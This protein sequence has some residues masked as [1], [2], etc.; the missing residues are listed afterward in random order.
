MDRPAPPA[1]SPVMARATSAKPS[2]STLPVELLDGI[3]QLVDNSDLIKLR[4]VSKTICAI[5]SR[6]FAARNFT[7]CYHVMSK[8]S[9]ETLLAISAHSI[10]G[11]CIK[12]IMVNSTRAILGY[13]NRFVEDDW[14]VES[15]EFS[16][17][18]PQILANIRRHTGSIT[19]GILEFYGGYKSTNRQRFHGENLFLAAG[20]EI[21]SRPS[22]TL[23]L[24][25][26]QMNAA[27]VD[28]NGLHFTV[29]LSQNA[30]NLANLKMY[31]MVAKFLKSRDSPIDLRFAWE[32]NKGLL[33]YNHLRS[34]LYFSAPT[35]A[36]DPAHFDVEFIE[37]TV[38][39]LSETSLSDV[40]LQ[41]LVVD[42]LPFLEV[43]L[44]QSVQTI[45]LYDIKV[46]STHFA[47]GLYSD[48]FQS[49]SEFPNLRYC[50]FHRFHYKLSF[51]DG[52]NEM[53]LISGTY[54]SNWNSL[55]LIFPD[56][57][58]EIVIQGADTSKQ[59][60]KLAA[61]TTAAERRKVQE[62]EAAGIL[63][64]YRVMGADTPIFEEEDDDYPI[65]FRSS[66]III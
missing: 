44:T 34:R 7:S 55:L 16:N 8:H 13:R 1:D 3:F 17:L 35:M 37:E 2:L 10:F 50:K 21:S 60:K 54:E 57:K 42:C 47:Q 41:D 32:E 26:A 56:G 19:I 25:L 40:H 52:E 4:F 43:Y 15:G 12:K 14:F 61:Y 51:P 64:E 6:P 29:E 58:F 11:T 48:L 20:L 28:I 24:V 18:M 27:R 31:K 59:L 9:F 23:E 5:A 63:V 45:T 39:W 46:R 33:E 49:L 53:Q 38:Q 22:E 66:E 62:I 30:D 65:C 36:L